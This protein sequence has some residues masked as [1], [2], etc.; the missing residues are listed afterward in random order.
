MLSEHVVL[1]HQFHHVGFGQTESGVMR[2]IV[3][4][5]SGAILEEGIVRLLACEEGL[6][7]LDVGYE[8]EAALVSC[9]DSLVPDIVILRRTS[10]VSLDRITDLILNRP[11]LDHVQI[12]T[13]SESS[14]SIIIFGTAGVLEI[15]IHGWPDFLTAINT[16]LR[17]L[18]K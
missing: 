5:N 14:S 9:L 18:Q 12:V 10:S 4:V 11:G 13:V 1:N 7:V 8:D 2:R 6:E 3:V 16:L 17:K 15:D